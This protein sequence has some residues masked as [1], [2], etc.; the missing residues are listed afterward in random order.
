MDYQLIEDL[1]DQYFEGATSLEEEK[2]LKHFFTYE[3][4]PEH[5]QSLQPLFVH[6]QLSSE[7]ALGADF[8]QS[9][10][11]QLEGR[12][13]AKIR[14]LSVKTWL[15]RAAAIILIAGAG[16]W[17]FTPTTPPTTT[18][19]GIDWSKYEVQDPE[20]AFKLTQMALLKASTELN[21][22]ANTA[23]REVSNLRE[24]GQFFKK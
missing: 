14:R 5:L 23:A 21:K 12:Q 13:E 1:L 22:G 20:E 10:L 2:Q 6:L 18:T 11:E 8:D 3:E 15:S 19:G 9:L 7:D 4:V 24:I 17:Y 16:W